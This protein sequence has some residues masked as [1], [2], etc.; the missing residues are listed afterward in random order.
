MCC[1]FSKKA[2]VLSL[3]FL[4]ARFSFIVRIAF[5]LFSLLPLRALLIILLNM[6]D[7]EMFRTGTVVSCNTEP[8]DVMETDLESVKMECRPKDSWLSR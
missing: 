4:I 2:L 3:D 8:N 1:Y 5:F 6:I 7:V